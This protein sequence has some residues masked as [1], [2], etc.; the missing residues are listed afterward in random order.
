MTDQPELHM[1]LY[2]RRNGQ[3]ALAACRGRNKG[4]EKLIRA[5]ERKKLKKPCDE[6]VLADNGNETVGELLDRVR[7]GDA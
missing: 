1:L 7:R 4:C 5:S 3:F 6:C 2:K